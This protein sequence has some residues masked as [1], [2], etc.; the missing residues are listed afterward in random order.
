MLFSNVS[1]QRTRSGA[2]FPAIGDAPSAA[3]PLRSGE[4]SQAGHVALGQAGKGPTAR[5]EVRSCNPSVPNPIVRLPVWAAYFG[6]PSPPP[7][8]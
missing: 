2:G 3:D 4:R 1:C 5:C 8:V 7:G 6:S